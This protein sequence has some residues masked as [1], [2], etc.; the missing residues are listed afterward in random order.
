MLGTDKQVYYGVLGLIQ[1]AFWPGLAMCVLGHRLA[2]H[3]H[4]PGTSLA[5]T[6]LEIGKT[7]AQSGQGNLVLHWNVGMFGRRSYGI[8]TGTA[9]AQQYEAWH[10]KGKNMAHERHLVAQQMAHIGN[11]SNFDF[12]TRLI[13]RPLTYFWDVICKKYL[14][15]VGSHKPP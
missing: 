4:V 11:Y 13:V 10:N 9:M 1:V 12:D 3:W 14:I 7:M 15:F 6:G 5:H 8:T 2:L